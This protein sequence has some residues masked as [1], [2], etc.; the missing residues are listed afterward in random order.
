M[1]YATLMV[2]LELGHANTN[3]LR[4]TGEL[5]Q[6][7][8]AS[9]MGIAARQPLE[10]L[11]GDAYMAGNFYEQDE[12]E[13]TRELQAAEAEF[14]AALHHCAHTIEW[15]SARTYTYLADYFASEARAAD[16]VITGVA[17]GDVLDS[18]RTLNTGD[19]VM[20]AGRPVLTVPQLPA[21]VAN[22][23][24]IA[25]K[26]NHVLVAWKDTRE[27]RRAASDALPLLQQA[28]D[29]SVVEIANEADLDAAQQR[30]ADVAHW[31]KRHHINA[32]GAAQLSVGN[33]AT[34]L[35]GL[36]EEKG[37]DVIV[38]GAYGHSRLREWVLGGVTRD[39][40]LSPNRCSFVSH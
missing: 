27:A 32:K 13:L 7:F 29:V 22:N 4:V 40:L 21:A 1:T 31:L 20:Q 12:A 6:R 23:A 11:Y 16:L 33:D 26:L 10:I 5:A 30:V 14:R 17:T 18:S 19:L 9:V 28:T 34:A 3:L 37:A 38:A 25:L 24:D 39:L 15:R 8:K 36:C 35:R 2:H